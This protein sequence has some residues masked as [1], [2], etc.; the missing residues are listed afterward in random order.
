MVESSSRELINARGS[1]D[2]KNGSSHH[3]ESSDGK[4]SYYMPMNF[5]EHKTRSSRRH[6][7]STR[8]APQKLPLSP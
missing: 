5:E 4:E 1:I 2:K 6:D 8:A 7:I 3:P